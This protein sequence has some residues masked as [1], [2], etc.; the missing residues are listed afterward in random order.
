MI[1][2]DIELFDNDDIEF[3]YKT[4]RPRCFYD[5]KFDGK[6]SAYEAFYDADIRWRMIINRIQYSG[7]FIDSKQVL[8][9]LNITR[10]C[11]Q[12]SLLIQFQIK[13]ILVQIPNIL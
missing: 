12:L 3:P 8:N 7:G 13:V 11:K 6:K 5:V 10:T 1:G 4:D 9:A 2:V